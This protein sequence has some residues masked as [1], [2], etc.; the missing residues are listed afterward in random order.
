MLNFSFIL[1]NQQEPMREE[2]EKFQDLF[3]REKE[4]SSGSLHGCLGKGVG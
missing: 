1:W 2:Y 3:P 4:S